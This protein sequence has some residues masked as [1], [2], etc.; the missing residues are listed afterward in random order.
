MAHVK[1]T[2]FEYLSV[3]KIMDTEQVT[4]YPIEKLNPL[5]LSGVPLPKLRL[6]IGVLI[7]LMH[8]LD[9]PKLCNGTRLQVI[10]MGRNIVKVIIKT[11]MTKRFDR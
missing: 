2:I 8:N 6:K 7:L 3:D 1:R 9:A 5:E 4:S 11:G 10:H